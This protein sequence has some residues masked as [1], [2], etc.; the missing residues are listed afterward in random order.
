MTLKI[1]H[2]F[3]EKYAI[4]HTDAPK[5]P[6]YLGKIIDAEN[7]LHQLQLNPGMNLSLVKSRVGDE[8]KD[9]PKLLS[10]YGK[11]NILTQI[12]ENH[13]CQIIIDMEHIVS[14]VLYKQQ[15]TIDANV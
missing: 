13:G 6:V 12:V 14:I 5:N 8:K 11:E 1:P 4:I 9:F 7:T 3:N 2:E 15:R 10:E